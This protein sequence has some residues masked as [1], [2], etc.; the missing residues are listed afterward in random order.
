MRGERYAKRAC[1]ADPDAS[2]G[3]WRLCVKGKRNASGDDQGAAQPAHADK[4]GAGLH[5]L[6]IIP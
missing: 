3:E 5:G 6:G 2:R 4:D 1:A